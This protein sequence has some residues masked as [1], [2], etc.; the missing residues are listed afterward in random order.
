[1][2]PP[3]AAS[4]MLLQY[5]GRK[6]AWRWLQF[7]VLTRLSADA[8]QGSE[9]F[10]RFLPL[11]KLG[12]PEDVADL[13]AVAST[14][15]RPR[16]RA[17]RCWTRSRHGWKTRLICLLWHARGPAPLPRYAFISAIKIGIAC[18]DKYF[19]QDTRELPN[20]ATMWYV[21]VSEMPADG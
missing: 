14:P 12:Q 4:A 8:T 17:N 15:T 2:P 6:E 19:R 13:L 3:M 18:G 7:R 10:W 1:M 20:V 21:L 5:S 11:R 9:R 16:R